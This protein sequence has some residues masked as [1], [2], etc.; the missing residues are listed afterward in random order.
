MPQ[1]GMPNPGVPRP[2]VP[3]PVVPA[4]PSPW[5]VQ[6]PLARQSVI[7][8]RGAVVPVGP[9]PIRGVNT[10]GDWARAN[11]MFRNGNVNGAQQIIDAQL[12]R[13]R[14][15]QGMMTAMSVYDRA[16]I[17][18]PASQQLRTQAFQLA[19]T[20]IKQGANQPLPWVVVA[21][22]S[23]EERNDTQFR[24]T[25]RELQQRFPNSE[26][27]P[28]FIGIQQLQDRDFKG[29]EQSLRQARE[30][31]MPE[32]SIALLL[33][34]AIDNQRWIWEYTTILL[35]LIVLWLF[36]LAVLFCV[37]KILSMLTLHSIEQGVSDEISSSERRL[38][39]AYRI[40]INLAGIYY[41]L[42]LPMV[43]L[44]SIALPLSLG[45]AL[46]LLPYLNLWLVALVL[47][48][49]FGGVV[50]A[51]SGIRAAF[52]R[53]ER[54]Q[55]GQRIKPADAPELWETV[56]E[57]AD[58]VGTRCVDEIRIVPDANIC[59]SEK[60]GFLS[61][62]RDRSQRVLVLGIGA[63]H[64]LKL[65][66]FKAI[67]A[68]EYG[69]FQNRDTAGGDISLR[70]WM[71]M[72][73]FADAIVRAKKN[74]WY[75]VAFHFLRIYHY[76]FRRLAFGAS[77]LQEVLADR[78]AVLSYGRQ[79][80]VEGLTHAIRRAVE[81]D[82]AVDRAVRESIQT[83]QPTHAF[84]KL[85]ATLELEDREQV[86][87]IIRTILD[88]DTDEEDS[89]PSPKDR[90][91]LAAKVDPNDTPPPATPAWSLVAGSDCVV[92]AMDR[93]VGEAV[94]AAAVRVRAVQS[95]ELDFLTR[96]L[97]RQPIPGAFLERARLYMSRADYPRALDDLNEV[98]ERVKPTA[99]VLYRRAY[100]LEKLGRYSEAGE[101]LRQIDDLADREQLS[102]QERFMV[103]AMLGQCRA[104]LGDHH[105]AVRCFGTA[106]TFNTRSL[107]ALVERT[108]S[109]LALGEVR[110][111]LKDSSDAVEHWP[112]SPEAYRERS[113]AHAALGQAAA[114]HADRE[115]AK[116]LD[117][118]DLHDMAEEEILEVIPV[119]EA[120]AIPVLQAIEVPVAEE[121]IP[122]VYPVDDDVPVTSPIRAK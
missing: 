35:V 25:T 77:R 31:G 106:L 76:L 120:V 103:H 57:V 12:Q 113:R 56:R 97:R 74:R 37:G 1:P 28:Y 64:G 63:L 43:L 62:V 19:Q 10:G 22:H 73:R 45:Y 40:V 66:S 99:G 18:N 42:S 27:T 79:A 98:L 65:D 24:A 71:A 109:Y 111:A 15:L 61:R 26:Y 23:L 94:T 13:D 102:L 69:H 75:D 14:S 90:F 20:E 92:G 68:H 30:M 84:Y 67:L 39:Q 70:V 86:E 107:L 82:I 110:Q 78:V 44:V 80:F 11:D 3:Q 2:I 114:A 17:N 100:V 59:V 105:E 58:R 108:R 89:H 32:E 55:L 91:A 54:V 29:A 47:I 33:K 60:G 121:D 49:G 6:N 115:R 96:V 7:L 21:R 36:G 83:R 52:T 41:Y 95:A 48:V 122:I 104:R 46:L 119:V 93:L 51:V 117:R 116:E 87:T 118:L 4:P 9:V 8:P 53:G 112:N 81:F 34:A 38:R 72:D 50:T 16:N 5:V 101:D 88:R 85:S